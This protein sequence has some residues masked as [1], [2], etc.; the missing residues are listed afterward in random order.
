MKVNLPVTGHEVDYGDD[1]LIVSRTDLDGRI[2]FVNHDFIQISGFT[3]EELIGQSHNI[4]R[5][6]DMPSAAF[7]DFWRT[8]RSGKPWSGLV[9]NRCKNGDHYW[10]HADVT[11]VRESGQITG[12]L[13]VRSRPSRKEVEHAEQLYRRMNE[14]RHALQMREG[15]VRRASLFSR[16]NIIRRIHEQ[17]P[18]RTKFGLVGLLLFIPLVIALALTWSKFSES[19]DAAR[20]EREGLAY[21]HELRDLL[22]ALQNHRGRSGEA[23]VGN[24]ASAAALPGIARTLQGKLREV[25]D[26][27]ATLDA[28]LEVSSVWAGIRQDAEALLAADSKLSVD[29]S[30]ER[31]SA[32][33]DRVNAL[34]VRI[35]SESGLASD[36]D[37]VTL[38]LVTAGIITAP[39]LATHVAFSRRL[40]ASMLLRNAFD[41]P[42]KFDVN[43]RMAMADRQMERIETS[44]GNAVQRLPALEAPLAAPLASLKE[45]LG[46]F[47]KLVETRVLGAS[48]AEIDPAVFHKQGSAAV[49]AAYAL[50]DAVSGQIDLLLGQRIE[51]IR[52]Q[53]LQLFAGTLALF[54]L[55]VA[56]AWLFV[57]TTVRSLGEA[58]AR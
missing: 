7:Q 49:D 1:V 41:L 46:S 58:V 42:S 54:V 14:G 19:L 34:M 4:V 27:T 44:V 35:A 40:G 17:A 11:P 10:V 30:F 32:V 26:R 6:P 47:D 8:L 39:E 18:M 53:A 57:R 25:G 52:G 50:Y 2:T 15:V 3:P 13:S 9:K 24:T 23:K 28:R 38:G 51:R 21:H 56:V 5:H 55:G 37:P 36:A 12:Y 22:P 29:E 43:G 45:N 31:H 16:L 20:F 33:I 48:R